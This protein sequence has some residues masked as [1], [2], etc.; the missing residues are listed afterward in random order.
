MDV[1]IDIIE[2]RGYYR[3]NDVLVRGGDVLYIRTSIPSANFIV[4]ISNKDHFFTTAA[5]SINEDVAVSAGDVLLGTVNTVPAGE[6]TK[7]YIIIP[8]SST[9]IP[10]IDAPPRIIRVA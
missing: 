10:G 8:A 5:T 9:V 4:S 2:D 3:A 1:Y 6:L 7:L